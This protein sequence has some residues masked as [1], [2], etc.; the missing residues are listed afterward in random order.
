M[1]WRARRRLRTKRD[2][3]TAEELLTPGDF[4]GF[5]AGDGTLRMLWSIYPMHPRSILEIGSRRIDE[6]HVTYPDAIEPNGTGKRNFV[7]KG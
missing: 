2:G 1:C 5:K 7:L 6:D 4:F 3:V